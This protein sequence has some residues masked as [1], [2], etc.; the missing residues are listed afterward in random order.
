MA[1]PYAAPVTGQVEVSVSASQVLQQIITPFSGWE[2]EWGIDD[3]L[4]PPNIIGWANVV[5]MDVLKDI[6][7]AV[8]GYIT[9]H[10]SLKKLFLT[11]KYPSMPW[12]WDA[13]PPDFS[14]PLD[15]ITSLGRQNQTKPKYNRVYVAGQS[16]GLL[17]NCV[18]EGTAGDVMAP[19]IVDKYITAIE[20]A[21]Q[22][23][24]AVLGDVGR[25][26]IISVEIPLS[27]DIPLVI[28]G[29]LLE[30]RETSPWR[31]LSRTNAVSVRRNTDALEVYQTVGIER[32]Y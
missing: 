18:R 19:Q 30:V 14:I 20:A 25:Q 3:W 10:P 6:A 29:K 28:P 27:P 13:Q 31:G 12:E 1:A 22:R 2:Y 8:G 7:T 15:V 16:G 21:R 9:S 5:P 32:H 26:A 4:I 23:G 11:P 17:A 24:R